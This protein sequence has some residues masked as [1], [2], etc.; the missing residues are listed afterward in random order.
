MSIILSG[1][2]PS[3]ILHIGNYLG[4]IKN[5][6]QE[7]K[8]QNQTPNNQFFLFVADMHSLTTVTSYEELEQN[9][10]NTIAI[11]ISCGVDPRKVTIFL[12]SKIKELGNFLWIL[13]CF[14]PEGLL[15]KMTQYKAKKLSKSSVLNVGLYTYPVLMAAD[16]LLF[17]T[18]F[19]PV[20]NDQ[21][22]HV[23]F[24]RDLAKMFNFKLEKQIF[25]IPEVKLIQDSTRIMDL[26][27]PHKKM[28]KS[29]STN[30]G[31]LGILDS[32]DQIV[33]KIKK[34]TTDSITELS[35]QPEARPGISNLI[36]IYSSFTNMNRQEILH[37]H[38]NSTTSQL[39]S[40]LSQ[41][42]VEKLKP[43][44]R[45]YT[46]LI[47]DKGYLLRLLK[48]GTARAQDQAS[49]NYSKLVRNIL[50]LQL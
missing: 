31:R 2:Q 21:K 27:N 7:I 16:I 25:T 1:M 37:K 49:T 30:L 8:T 11:Y 15:N 28:S 39:K 19:V 4:A 24:T 18:N 10:L 32:N 44:Q 20:G 42:L 36:N 29:E 17:Q 13:S 3:G 5:L 50:R 46:S 33:Q 6:I 40:D 12:Q 26:R 45:K 47:Q 23:E 35:F 9:V 38:S 43:I 22:Q 48:E 41:I 14:T 34:A